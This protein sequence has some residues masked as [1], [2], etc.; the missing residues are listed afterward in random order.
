[1]E[2]AAKDRGAVEQAL[3]RK[4]L[5][6]ESF[7]QRLLADPKATI[8]QELG[9]EL[10]ADLEVRV[11][12]EAPKTLYLVLPPSKASGELSDA[13]LDAVAGGPSG[14]DSTPSTQKADYIVSLETLP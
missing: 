5:Q 3:V 14:R 6:D 2:E 12:E 11:L 4:S 7:R 10:P 8:E 13:E 9:R 1:M